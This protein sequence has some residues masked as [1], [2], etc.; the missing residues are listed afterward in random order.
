M[1]QKELTPFQK[2]LKG[3]KEGF[4]DSLILEMPK[5]LSGMK[6][7]FLFYTPSMR[8]RYSLEVPNDDDIQDITIRFKKK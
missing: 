3:K 4:A 5:K 7:V 8:A 1:E 2:A 6:T